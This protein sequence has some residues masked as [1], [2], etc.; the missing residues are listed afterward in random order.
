MEMIFWLQYGLPYVIR[1][2]SSREIKSRASQVLKWQCFP[3]NEN[4][5]H[6]PG[7]WKNSN[8]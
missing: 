1:L 4:L 2:A 6:L 3:Q 8:F 5:T 7:I